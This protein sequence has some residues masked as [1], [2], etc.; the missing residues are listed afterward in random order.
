MPLT[1]P[2]QFGPEAL[3]DSRT[4][5]P[6]PA[7]TTVTA[8]AGYTATFSA[9]NVTV[10]GPPADGVAVTITPP[11]GT[12]QTVTVTVPPATS[13]LAAVA[14]L[15]RAAETP[16]AAQGKADAARAAAEATAATALAGSETTARA[17]FVA[18]LG[19]SNGTD[20]TAAINAALANPLGLPKV[21]RGLP[22]QTY[23]IS[24]PPTIYS[25]TTLDMS[26]CVVRLISGSNSNMLRNVAA[27]TAQRTFSGS[28]SSGS[29]TLTSASAV[30]SA[31]V[32]RT[33]VVPGAGGASNGLSARVVSVDTVT[34]GLTLSVAATTTVTS[35]SVSIYDRDKNIVVR[36][37]FWDR[38][39]NSGTDGISLHSLLFRRVDGL[40][41]RDLSCA[42]SAGKYFVA[43]GDVTD[44][45]VENISGKV[46]S[47]IVQFNGPAERIVV[48]NVSGTSQDDMVAFT[49]NDYA[50]YADTSGSMRDVVVDGV[51]PTSTGTGVAV[52]LLPGAG[53]TVDRAVIRDVRGVTGTTTAGVYLGD[54][55]GTPGTT[56][57]SF[58]SVTVDGVS[59]TCRIA[60]FLTGTPF[61]SVR[62][63]N[64]AFAPVTA[65]TPA[66][67]MHNFASAKAMYVN[68]LVV[69]GSLAGSAALQ[70]IA[71]SSLDL[72]VMTGLTVPGTPASSNLII[73]S[74]GVIRHLVLRDAR[75]LATTS[76]NVVDVRGTSTLGRLDVEAGY[77]ESVRCILNTASTAPGLQMALSGVAVKTPSRLVNA[78]TAVEVDV[79]NLYVDSAVAAVFFTPGT[80]GSLVVR[81][82]SVRAVGT[83]ALVGRAG[84]QP[85]RVNGAAL[86]A[87]ITIL[88]PSDGDQVINTNGSALTGTGPVVYNTA[89]AKWKHLYTAATT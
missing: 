42:E 32:G 29:S 7:G 3:I 60:V 89:A 16:A 78:A 39:T 58:G 61:D 34:S 28:I 1:T 35:V 48:R 56:G 76:T 18:T 57:G 55:Q 2:G 68:G 67:R 51:F 15:A 20:D 36:G 46:N 70:M 25:N 22:G 73:L 88:T 45:L 5:D 12:A 83:F 81:G 9:G 59:V 65:D 82:G 31:D 23:L 84:S 62:L 49:A 6:L 38:G 54:D 19:L 24:V 26:G 43:P 11:G 17:T 74:S 79:S 86:A 52:K 50:P 72:L 8:P 40:T 21:V 37:G 30:T 77:Y 33:V 53:C 71:D 85:L 4:G 69:T 27:V 75:V 10:T 44:V 13:E 47:A 64:I 87:D 14:D 41:V 66:I 63:N 80:T